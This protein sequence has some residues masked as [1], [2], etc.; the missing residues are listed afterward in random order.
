MPRKARELSKTGLYHVMMR[1]IDRQQVFQDDED[2]EIFLWM[3][4]DC[5]SVSEFKLY[6]YCLM[7]NHV[8]LL[9]QPQ[10]ED[11]GLTFKR[12][13]VKYVYRYNLKYQRVGPLF[14]DRFKSEAINS[15]RHFLAA[16]RYIH[17]NPIKAGIVKKPDEYSWSSYGEYL[18]EKSLVDTDFALK[19]IGADEFVRFHDIS[20]KN[21]FMDNI[22]KP[23]GVSD[24]AVK[25]DMQERFGISTIQD[26]R[27][28]NLAVRLSYLRELKESGASIR[29][30]C[31]LLGESKSVVERA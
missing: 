12:L 28:L 13:G 9:M 18:G 21:D 23:R 20:E 2:N 15:E 31:R 16:V 14:Q 6:A 19:I 30:L 4:K 11:L 3:L 25:G 10:T 29:Q 24:K 22:A 27:E 26:F 7:G 1:G 17:Q 5:K 8:H